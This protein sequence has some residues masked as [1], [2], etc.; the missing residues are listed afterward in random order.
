[1]FFNK[2]KLCI[3]FTSSSSRKEDKLFEN[4]YGYDNVKRLFRMALQSAHN[5]SILLSGPPASAKTLFLQL[6][7]KLQDSYFIDCSNAT[8]SGLV[9]FIFDNKPKYLLLDELDKLSKR[10][11][12]FLLNLMET[13]IVSETKYN[14]TRTM[15]IRT[16][17]FATS[18]NTEKIIPPLQSRFFIVKLQQY[19]Y[20]QFYD[21][22]IRLLTTSNQHNVDEEIAKVTADEVWNISSTTKNIRDC[23]RVAKMAKSV[24]DVKWLVKSFL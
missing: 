4:I 23:V 24:E 20:E 14:R 22:T 3:L 19:T 21:I 11:Q 8:K 5:T 17:I 12:T 18:N 7:M 15:K 16:S 6:L 10:D 1:M 13:G 9:D 2:N